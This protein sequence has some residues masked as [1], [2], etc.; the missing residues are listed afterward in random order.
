MKVHAVNVHADGR[1]F[2]GVVE[3]RVGVGS[4]SF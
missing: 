2:F 4:V 3:Y 1:D